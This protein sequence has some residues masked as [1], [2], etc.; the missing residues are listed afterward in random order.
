MRERLRRV[1][2][3]FGPIQIVVV[4]DVRPRHVS[5]EVGRGGGGLGEVGG[6]GDNERRGGG[7]GVDERL[8]EMVWGV[9]GFNR[10]AFA[11]WQQRHTHHTR[12]CLLLYCNH[13]LPL[14]FNQ[15]NEEGL[16]ELHLQRTKCHF[17]SFYNLMHSTNNVR[18]GLHLQRTGISDGWM[19]LG[20]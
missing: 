5:G 4:F 7:G 2:L 1:A 20:V 18:M 16:E 12:C 3:V 19:G 8:R 10:D 15:L 11:T 9:R 13:R 6:G 14:T 17:F